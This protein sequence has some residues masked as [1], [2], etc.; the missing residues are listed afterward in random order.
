MLNPNRAT[1]CPAPSRT[2]SG[3]DAASIPI[4]TPISTAIRIDST[5]SSAVTGR[6]AAISAATLVCARAE[7]PRFP[8]ST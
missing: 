8:V 1:D 3:R 2:E 7:K 4:G 6:E 5:A